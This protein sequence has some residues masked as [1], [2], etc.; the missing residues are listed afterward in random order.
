MSGW[1]AI[2]PLGGPFSTTIHGDARKVILEN[3]SR[4]AICALAS[5]ERDMLSAELGLFERV[6]EV[7]T[8]QTIGYVPQGQRLP[9][10]V[11]WDLFE[12]ILEPALSYIL[13]EPGSRTWQG[14]IPG[15]YPPL[16]LTMRDEPVDCELMIDLL[17][18]CKMFG[19]VNFQVAVVNGEELG[20]IEPTTG[21]PFL[22]AITLTTFLVCHMDEPSTSFWAVSELLTVLNQVESHDMLNG[23]VL[24]W[25]N[26]SLF[27]LQI[28]LEEKLRDE[29]E[30]SES[31]ARP[32]PPVMSESLLPTLSMLNIAPAALERFLMLCGSL[33]VQEEESVV[34]YFLNLEEATATTHFVPPEMAPELEQVVEATR[35]GWAAKPLRERLECLRALT[36]IDSLYSFEQDLVLGL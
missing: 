26:A 24:F 3:F 15:F 33:E 36:R 2:C 14:N 19:E 6:L 8:Q 32:F 20:E 11:F 7:T 13:P 28:R 4:F 16:M 35:Q 29:C 17:R 27:N 25:L 18:P 31:Q 12:A 30:R 21:K 5:A 1:Y 22:M 23:E 9:V 10:Q 34:R